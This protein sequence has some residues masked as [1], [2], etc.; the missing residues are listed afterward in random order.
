MNAVV[1]PDCFLCCRPGDLIQ[2]SVTVNPLNGGPLVTRTWLCR[3]HRAVRTRELRRNGVAIKHLGVIEYIPDETLLEANGG[4]A[5]RAVARTS[6]PPSSVLCPLC[7]SST[8]IDS[9]I[10]ASDHPE[11]STDRRQCE[12]CDWHSD[13]WPTS[14]TVKGG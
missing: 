8:F 2:Q 1:R 6:P 10:P 13:E 9:H 11:L 12:K 3:W 4:G 14:N 5:R 7:G